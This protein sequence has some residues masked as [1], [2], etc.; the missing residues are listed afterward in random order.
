MTALTTRLRPLFGAALLG[1][2]SAPLMLALADNGQTH[3]G[4]QRAAHVELQNFQFSRVRAAMALTKR[5]NNP[6]AIPVNIHTADPQA[7]GYVWR[8]TSDV[9][10]APSALEQ[11][12]SDPVR[13]AVYAPVQPNGAIALTQ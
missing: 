1:I 7:P 3:R 4:P 12:D 6:G 2:A 5:A 8:V 10:S 9:Q 13:V 11:Y